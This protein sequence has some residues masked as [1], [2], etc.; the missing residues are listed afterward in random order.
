MPYRPQP[1]PFAVHIHNGVG[2]PFLAL[3]V[4]LVLVALVCL[5]VVWAFR[6]TR[7]PRPAALAAGMPPRDP[8]LDSVRMRYA[9]GEI[10]RDEFLQT[11]AD[12][13]APLPATQ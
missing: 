6:L 1:P 5:A 2:H 13:G 11:S 3:L 7:G 10:G 8:A 9:R 12:L 4:V